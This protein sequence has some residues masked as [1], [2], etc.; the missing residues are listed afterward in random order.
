MA[1]YLYFWS[2]DSRYYYN[3]GENPWQG[4]TDLAGFAGGNQLYGDGRVEWR[5][6]SKFDRARIESADPT[7]GF[8]R[9]YSVTRTIY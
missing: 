8:V 9:G 1:D 2:G 6:A 3:H 4:E 7:T 5:S